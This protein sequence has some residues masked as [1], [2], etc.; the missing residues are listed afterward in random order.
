MAKDDYFVLA[1]KFLRHLYD[2]LKEG[3][4]PDRDYLKAGTKDFPIGEEYWEY[5]V[6]NLAS[7]GMIEGVALLPVLGS[8]DPRIK[9]MSGPRITPKGI[10]YLQDNNMMKKAANFLKGVKDMTPGL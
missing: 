7:E 2:C 8:P 4:Q 10:E 5:L 6:R 3:R 9:I 1:Y